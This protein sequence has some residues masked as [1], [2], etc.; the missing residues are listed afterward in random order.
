MVTMEMDT[1]A[2]VSL[3][4]EAVLTSPLPTLQLQKTSVNLKTYTGQPIPVKGT[5]MVESIMVN[6]LTHCRWIRPEPDGRDWLKV[7]KL[8]WKTI[9][10]LSTCQ[11]VDSRVAAVQKQYQSAFSETLG[12]ITPFK[13]KLSVTA[14]TRPKFFKPRPL[15]FV[16]RD[17]VESKLDRLERDGFMEKTHYGE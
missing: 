15:P 14:D 7:V 8:D 13:A 5:V 12:T 16:L 6:K 3:A 11:N 1:G 2:A 9:G 17:R 4:S 10:R